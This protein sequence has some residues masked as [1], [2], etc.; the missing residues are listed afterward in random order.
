MIKKCVFLLCVLFINSVFADECLSYKL[1]PTVNITI[2]TWEKTVVQPLQPMDVL[3]GNVIATMVDNYEITTDITSIEDGFCVSLKNIDATVG[4][5][6]FLVQIDKS[7]RKDS[8]SYNAILQHEDEHIRSY[9]SVI[10]DNKKMLKES[11]LSAAESIIPV[12]VSEQKDIESVVDK[13]NEQLQNH[14]DIV[15]LKQHIKAEEEIRNKQVDLKDTGET[16]KKCFN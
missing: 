4:Y 12:F 3:H 9:L 1:K 5:T 16:L 15:L 7:N 6:D 10:E 8:C 11:V 13:F 2:P 14:P